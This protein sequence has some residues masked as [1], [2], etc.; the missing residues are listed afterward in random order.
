MCSVSL[1]GFLSCIRLEVKTLYSPATKT[2]PNKS[3][4]KSKGSEK[5]KD[6]KDESSEEET[7]NKSES[8]GGDSEEEEETKDD[9]Q[10]QFF[11]AMTKTLQQ[12]HTQTKILL[13]QMAHMNRPNHDPNQ[14][15]NYDPN[16]DP[17]FDPQSHFP[18]NPIP[19]V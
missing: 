5:E 14:D 9:G 12:N 11:K 7:E 10:K 18:P 6:G 13:K 4:R 8:V 19:L 17:N 1:C 3:K 2:M 15:S 16:F